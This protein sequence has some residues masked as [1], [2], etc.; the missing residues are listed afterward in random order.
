LVADVVVTIGRVISGTKIT[1]GLAIAAY[2]GIVALL[3]KPHEDPRRENDRGG[4]SDCFENV[5]KVEIHAPTT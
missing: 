5:C 4:R 1:Y 3:Q 2:G